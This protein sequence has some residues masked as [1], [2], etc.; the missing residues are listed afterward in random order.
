M[1][2]SAPVLV[3]GAGP[4]GLTVANLLAARG[5][6][7][8][9]VE[10]NRTTSD[11]AK[12]ISL[13][14]ESLR[15][16]QAAD[17]AERVLEIVVPGTGTRYYDRNGRPLFHARGP[18]PNRLG[19][20]FKNQ[21]AQPE[22][23]RLLLDALLE[24]PEAQVRFS[25]ELV[26][27]RDTGSSVHAVVRT[28]GGDAEELVE[29]R[30]VLGCDG[31][32]STV[33]ELLG[34]GMTGTSH[35]D[36]WLVADTLHDTHDERYGMHH[37]NPRRPMVIVPGRDGRCRY[38]FRLRL[39]EGEKGRPEFATIQKLLR[40][41]R[42][43]SPE[44]IERSTNYTFN[45]VVAERWRDGR[46][47]L[48]GDAAHMMPPFAGQGLNSGVRDAANLAWKV[49]QVWHGEAEERLLDTYQVERFAHA[50]AMVSFSERLG[51]VVMTVQP[52]R[53]L[54]RDLVARSML[55]TRRG[56]R[57][58]EEMRFRPRAM[59][60]EGF[61][62]RS[63]HVLVGRLLP[64]PQVL[65]PLSLRPQLLDTVLGEGF[66]LLGVNVPDSAWNALDLG[67]RNVRLIDVVLDDRMPPSGTGRAAVA[68]ADGALEESLGGARDCFV[69]VK[70]D[71]YI[72]AVV[73]AAQSPL[74]R[75]LLDAHLGCPAPDA[76]TRVPRPDPATS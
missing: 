15:T 58:L 20:P 74:L 48:L 9:L 7:V 10:R 37:G 4:V 47:F 27:L 31:G 5:V 73:P 46:C 32:R 50:R 65:V 53:A 55:L 67:D 11:E 44:Q 49:A 28:T 34:I 63:D 43:L 14:D 8:I 57:Y 36:V 13:D 16:L 39:G 51:R 6:Q 17:L 33:R 3:V 26:A 41:W 60:T 18:R 75:E 64:Q 38:E 19:Y 59:H 56:R 66:A 52:W 21:F 25:S 72:G 23:E 29:A 54:L 70:P 61:V 45:A 62:L 42:S 71:R 2:L 12:A 40:P 76:V 69:L 68:D 24:R 35:H 22:L 1:N 30:W